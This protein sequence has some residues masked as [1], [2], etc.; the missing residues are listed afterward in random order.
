[1]TYQKVMTRLDS[2]T[3]LG[4]SCAGTIVAV[5]DDIS[6]MQVGEAVAC[7]GAG[8]ANHA[9]VVFVP[10]NLVAKIPLPRS[11]SL[12]D[13]EHA[14]AATQ[15][16]LIHATA[17]CDVGFEQASFAT[18]G[19]IALQ[20]LRQAQPTL[21]ETIVVLGLGLLGLL[22]AQ[23]LKANGC[24]VLGMD[25]DPA[26]CSLAEQLGADHTAATAEQILSVVAQQTGGA[27]VDAVI[28]TASTKSNAPLELAAELCRDRGR[29]VVVGLVGLAVP[30]KPFYEKELDLR[31]SRSYGPGRYDPAYE[32]HGR[33]YPIGYVRWTENRNMQAFLDLLASGKVQVQ[34]LISHRFPIGSATEAYDLIAGKRSE[35][36]I[37]VILTYPR[38]ATDLTAAPIVRLARPTA[39]HAGQKLPEV[40]SPGTSQPFRVGLIGSGAFAQGTLLPALKGLNGVHLHGVCSAAGLSARHV[41]LKYGAVY[42]TTDASSIIHDPDIDA[43]MVATRHGSHSALATQALAAGKPVI[44]E[45]PLAITEAQLHAIA[46]AYHG[47]QL[48]G[49][50]GTSTAQPNRGCPQLLVGFNRRFAPL[51]LAMREFLADAG[52][53]V[54]H[55]RVNA[56]FLAPDSWVHDP[57]DGGGPIIGE[58]CHFIDF[59]QFLTGA[60][61]TQ[62][63]ATA[64]PTLDGSRR[65]DNLCAQIRFAEGSVGSIL[66]AT[67]G[68][69]T[70][71]K[72]RVEAFG[73]GRVAVLDDFRVL[74]MVKAGRRRRERQLLKQDKGHASELDVFVRAVRGHTPSPIAFESLVLTT[75]TTLRIQDAL[76]TDRPQPIGWQA[77]PG[78]ASM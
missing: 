75:L 27:G 12:T 19:A 32:E 57:V 78:P 35:R 3:P 43:I 6:D 47:A 64:T 33:D 16:T 37:G 2:T 44:V 69:K 71:P 9:E 10:R 70:F 49:A 22:T 34:P 74:D 17:G 26:R 53:L 52:P 15:A 38:A 31:L 61:P 54:I 24:R 55:Y 45:K 66:Y 11:R 21:G 39:R 8:Y 20:G 62:V 18:V 76:L 58:V 65:A 60:A 13:P 77:F 40:R 67:G 59:L 4:Y 73:G 68:D 1:S 72:E 51:A 42:C 5:A 36:A 56:G 63:S 50:A 23:M 28:I 48:S 46:V 41:A 25:V 14:H 30:R 29:V 7:A